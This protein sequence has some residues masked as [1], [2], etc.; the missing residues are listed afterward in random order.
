MLDPKHLHLMIASDTNYAEFVSVV[1]TSLFANNRDV[2]DKITVHLFSNGIIPECVEKIRLTIPQDKGELITYDIR[3]ISGRLGV[4]AAGETMNICSYARLLLTEYVDEEI[5]RIIYVDCDVVITGSLYEMWNT[6][7]CDNL[8]AGVLDAHMDAKPKTSIGM[9]DNYPYVN[10]GVLLINIDEWRR[11]DI[12]DKFKAF[13]LKYNG[14][15]YHQDQGLIN[16]V[17]SSRIKILGPEYNMTS[18]FFSHPHK[19]LK[20]FNNPFYTEEELESAKDSPIIIHFT[21][22]FLGRPWVRHCK[23]PYGYKFLEF[24]NSTPWRE[25]PLRDDK[26]S[27]PLK[28]TS[29]I[30]L[31]MPYSFYEAILRLMNI[32]K[33]NR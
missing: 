33:R 29:W 26:R 17:C 16:G 6:E 20:Q 27:L 25:V 15:V 31:N 4:N 30:F 1:T 22:G 2:F 23:H 8:V 19:L 14:N 18:Y 3:D 32:I 12:I 11:E 21:E 13:I 24:H 10:A 7:L 5:S 28:V 9:P